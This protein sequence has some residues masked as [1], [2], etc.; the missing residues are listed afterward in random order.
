LLAVFVI[1]VGALQVA[2]ADSARDP[3]TPVWV[4]SRGVSVLQPFGWGL[5]TGGI[6]AS[7]P[8]QNG[9][10][11][12]SVMPG[13]R[14]N[15]IKSVGF[16]FVR[17]A[18][19]PGPMLAASSDDVLRGLV[20]EITAAVAD[21]NAS[22]LKVI[23][24][25]HANI[26]HPVV[27]WTN[28]DLVDGPNGPKF[29]RLV[30]IEQRL[31][32]ALRETR[33]TDVA[34]ELF[35]EPPFWSRGA[36]SWSVQQK[37]L[38]GAVRAELPNHSIVVTGPEYSSIRGLESLE[39]LDY[40][41]NTIYTFHFY[42]PF[43]FALQ[44]SSTF[45]RN[46]HRLTF[47][48]Q[49]HVGGKP[50]AIADFKAT[51]ASAGEIADFTRHH[52]SYGIDTYFDEP[53][54]EAFVVSRIAAVIRWARSKGLRADQLLCGE[55][56]AE[57]D[58]GVNIAAAPSSRSA[59]IETVRKALEAADIAW[60]VH[61]LNNTSDGFGIASGTAPFQFDAAVMRALGLAN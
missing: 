39:P 56:G 24:D 59:Y 60:D 27:G 14:R 36:V 45:Y 19:D 52:R 3:H 31:A 6:Y 54:D 30:R 51:G 20:A 15:A 12:I 53:E 44:S 57:G 34:F 7:D 21:L 18:V 8:Y 22:G 48:P 26:S 33:P 32:A 17:L 55:F 28:A 13:T 9:G 4:A 47:P 1:T 49:A 23:V 42:E 11:W 16:D 46:I 2:V 40:D 43:Q 41:A 29:Q 10:T 38:F 35:N 58:H 5:S 50:K 37:V 25:I 61:E